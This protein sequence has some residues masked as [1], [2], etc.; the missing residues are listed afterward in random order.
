MAW[1]K[2]GTRKLVVDGVEFMWHRKECCEC[3]A[4]VPFL[5]GKSGGR[6]VLR[7]EVIDLEI[8][9]R[10]YARAM[11]WALA[12]GWSAEAGPDRRLRFNDETETFEW[13]PDDWS[14][15][16]AMAQTAFA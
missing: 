15:E 7:V 2:K 4:G 16:Q 5:M 1:P 6:Y 12:N 14:A 9:P 13:I 3:T 11:R 10:D 8:R